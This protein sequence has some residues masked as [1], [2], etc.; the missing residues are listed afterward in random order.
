V[1]IV[2]S[3]PIASGKSTVARALAAEYARA[4]LAVAVIDLDLIHGMLI[5]PRGR[6][7]DDV[8]Q[9]A[10]RAAGALARAFLRAGATGVIVEGEFIRDEERAVF[11]DALGGDVDLRYVTLLVSYDQALHRARADRTRGASRDPGFLRPYFS[12]VEPALAR[13]PGSDLLLNTEE[14]SVD[15]AVAAIWCSAS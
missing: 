2:V 5:P 12:Q 9:Q 14:I 10:R 1:V 3:G 15:A 13:T 6:D 8:W 11:T 7:A 4:D